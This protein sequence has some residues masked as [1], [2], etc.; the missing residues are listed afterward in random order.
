MK[1][2]EGITDGWGKKTPKQMSQQRGGVW[3]EGWDDS[4]AGFYKSAY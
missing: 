2:V 4:A 1:M 3:E